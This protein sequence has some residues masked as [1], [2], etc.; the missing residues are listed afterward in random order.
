MAA[1]S[2]YK[3][4]A[5]YYDKMYSIKDYKAESEKIRAFISKYK[6]SGG[7]DMLDVACGT[8]NHIQ[9]LKKYFNIT[10][11]DIDKDMLAIARKKFPKN[12]FIRW[13][14]RTFSLNK[15]FDVIVCLF[16][17]IAHLKTYANLDK[18]IRNFSRHLKPGGVVIIE[19]FI[20]SK[21]FINNILDSYTVNEPDLKLTRMNRSKRRGNI[22]IYDF[23]FLVG[24]KGRIRYFVDIIELGMF[25]SKRVLTMMKNAGLKSKFLRKKKE[26]RGRY[27]GVK[28]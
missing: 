27:I 21:Y 2:V 28:K 6:T 9:Y 10:G 20:D 15:Q 17:A 18:T 13:D 8:G 16:S 24:E 1:K 25:D 12:K 3:S 22:A 7:K 14:M 19:P 5:K 23:H 4:F 26:Y 11:I